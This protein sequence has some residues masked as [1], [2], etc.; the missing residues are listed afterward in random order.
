[1]SNP[2][3]SQRWKEYQ[4]LHEIK[5]NLRTNKQQK[6]SRLMVSELSGAP[7]ERQGAVGG[8]QLSIENFIKLVP[9]RR[10]FVIGPYLISS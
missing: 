8:Q 5:N 4:K 1:M 3:K 10:L 2:N 6:S 7:L 9:M